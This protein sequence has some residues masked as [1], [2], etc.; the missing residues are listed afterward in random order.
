MKPATLLHTADVHLGNGGSGPRSFEARAFSGALD[1]AIDSDVDAVLVVGDL[2]DHARVADE[3][4]DWVGDE[5]DRVARPVVLLVGNHDALDEGSVHHRFRVTE[6]C[7]HVIFIDQPDG[8]IVEVPGTD[9]VVWGRA[10]IEHIRAFRPL[11][12]VPA[13]P[14]DR[15]GVVAA[16][17]IVLRTDAPSHH[18]SAMRPSELAAVKWDYVALGH[19]HGH[20]VLR[21][22]PCPAVYPGATAYSYRGDPGAVLVDLSAG[23]GATYEWTPIPVS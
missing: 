5:L 8:A 21:E 13:K 22:A 15:W 9:V 7:P 18:A 16:H 19:E 23:C 14:G 4:L 2:F 17:G 20:Q 6:R 1:L 12:G 11:D 3:L 10:M